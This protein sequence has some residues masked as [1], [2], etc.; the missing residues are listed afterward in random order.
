[1]AIAIPLIMGAAQVAQGMSAKN[2]DDQNAGIQRQEAGI[3]SSQG[4]AAEATQR[5]LGADVIGKQVAAAGQAGGGY[6]GSVGRAIGQSAQNTE[7]DALNIRYKA[8][9]QRWGYSTQARFTQ[10]EGKDA[11]STSLLRA[12]SAL[13][14]GY[15]S[16]YAG[17]KDLG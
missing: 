14:S 1:V 3:A 16:S 17:P 2:A 12:G 6:G 9:L 5:R 15:S 10:Q 4:Y 11:Q 8:G 13:L 7:L